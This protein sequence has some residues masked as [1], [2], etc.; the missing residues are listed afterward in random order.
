MPDQHPPAHDGTPHTPTPPHLSPLAALERSWARGLL[1][2]EELLGCL[3]H[4][5]AQQEAWRTQNRSHEEDTEAEVIQLKTQHGELR[6]P[7]LALGRMLR[8]IGTT[9]DK[10]TGQQLDLWK[11][12]GLWHW[13]WEDTGERSARGL[14]SHGEAL[15]DAVR[16]RAGLASGAEPLV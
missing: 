2:T 12:G 16:R 5:L 11:A 1:S 8:Q 13:R 9:L 7:S 14:R 15:V 3:L 4:H 6:T 10:L